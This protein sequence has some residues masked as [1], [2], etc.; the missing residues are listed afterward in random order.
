[1]LALKWINYKMNG[2]KKGSS[3]A[4]SIGWEGVNLARVI[5]FHGLL[6]TLA[7]DYVEFVGQKALFRVYGALGFL[8]I[9]PMVM[10]KLGRGDF[11]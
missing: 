3:E 9:L 5:E 7:N 8:F 6:F 11:V 1:M 2:L 10:Q 4:V